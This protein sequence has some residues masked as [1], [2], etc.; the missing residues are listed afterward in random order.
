MS[1]VEQPDT[2]RWTPRLR[3]W[4]HTLNQTGLGRVVGLLL[5]AA[6]PLSP[7]GAHVLWI[8]QPTLGLFTSREDIAALARLLE[9]P[10]GLAWLRGQLVGPDDESD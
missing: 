7:I 4:S 3:R 9:Q 2:E 6:E 8:A 1:T 5:D 10:G